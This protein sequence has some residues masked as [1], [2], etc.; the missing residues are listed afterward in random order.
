MMDWGSDDTSPNITTFQ[1]RWSQSGRHCGPHAPICDTLTYWLN[2]VNCL[3]RIFFF[4]FNQ[5]IKI[6]F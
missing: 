2:A 4:F 5:R 3:E 6:S 1:L